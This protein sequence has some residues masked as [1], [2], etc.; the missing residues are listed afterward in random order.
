MNIDPLAEQSRR[1]SPYTYA[2]DNP[3]FFIDR[4][5]MKAIDSNTDP[6]NETGDTF[7]E[8]MELVNATAGAGYDI[9]DYAQSDRLGAGSG[10][11]IINPASQK[12]WDRQKQNVTVQ[13]DISTIM[14]NA[15]T[16]GL[17]NFNQNVQSLNKTLENLSV[18]ENSKQVYSL[19]VLSPGTTGNTSFDSASG[20][21][22]IGFAGT[23]N[24][25]HESTHAGQFE[26]GDI[27]FESTNGKQYAVD[28]GDEVAAYK[29][30]YA[31]DP[32]SVSGLRSSTSVKSYSDITTSWVQNL[33]EPSG[34]RPYSQG[35]SLGTG[36]LPL[37]VNSNLSDIVKAFPG[38]N[39]T[40]VP[41]NWTYKSL[42]TFIYKKP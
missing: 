38:I 32:S 19:N 11:M 41:A 33:T 14:A 27:G 16:P 12:E 5:G 26:T 2:L 25:V 23:A 22:V 21:I 6:F 8:K 4:D 34:N 28:T 9:D 31:Y 29:A 36:I 18:L 1:F 13:R 40:G 30:Q 37:N 39:T 15:F 24:F 7:I 35:G 17:G 42:S 3:V 10:P 20:N